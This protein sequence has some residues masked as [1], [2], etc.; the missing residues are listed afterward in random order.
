MSSSLSCPELYELHWLGPF[1]EAGFS[2]EESE[3]LFLIWERLCLR[4]LSQISTAL[5][6]PCRYLEK[7]LI[8]EIAASAGFWR[9]LRLLATDP[10]IVALVYPASGQ[11]CYAFILSGCRIAYYVDPKYTNSEVV[12]DI[13]ET[14]SVCVD[15]TASL[16]RDGNYSVI[17][18]STG[19]R[20]RI[21]YLIPGL[22]S[23]VPDM[24]MKLVP[25][26]MKLIWLAKGMFDPRIIFP[27]SEVAR[28]PFCAYALYG[29]IN[30]EA[31]LLPRAYAAAVYDMEFDARRYLVFK[32][33]KPPHGTE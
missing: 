10:H 19:D 11:D 1:V 17:Q 9:S 14:I 13:Y 7:E 30:Q 26:S 20:P 5:K 27:G 29:L 22:D 18:F 8:S 15:A 23:Q 6:A 4:K 3:E 16:E 21:L 25:E 31:S 32:E 24:L 2:E 28:L 12:R 33:Y